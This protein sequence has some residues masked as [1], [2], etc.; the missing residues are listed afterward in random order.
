M[1]V[2][3]SSAP[4][5]VVR[6]VW[7]HAVDLGARGRY[8]PAW[9]LA[10]SLDDDP[11]MASLR[12]SLLGSHHRQI[13]D[14]DRARSHDESA[15]D[16][17]TDDGSVADALIGLAA[18]AVAIGWA[19]EAGDQLDRVDEVL[20]RWEHD[21]DRDE[22][23]M[24]ARGETTACLIQPWRVQVRRAWV[25]AEWALLTGVAD[26]AVEHAQIAVDLSASRSDRHRVKSQ[27]ILAAALLAQGRTEAAAQE[28]IAAGAQARRH[29]WASLLWPTALIA[30]AVEQVDARFAAP[31]ALID[32]GA[33][34]SRLIEVHLPDDHPGDLA[35]QWRARP[36]IADLRIR[37][38]QR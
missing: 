31:E 6:E 10:H 2:P 5:D 21:A 16:C 3:A 12:L 38:G 9:L 8:L 33:W 14:H 17:A 29:G 23:A 19:S 22:D 15:L 26:T 28:C 1:S 7:L 11:S 32:Q 27:A 4:D 37:A 18:D 36:D 25:R 13:G 20:A 30:L 34:A 24:V 35:A